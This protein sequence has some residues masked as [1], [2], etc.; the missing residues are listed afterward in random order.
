MTFLG[1]VRPARW[2]YVVVDVKAHV[3]GV[4]FTTMHLAQGCVL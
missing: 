2:A 1:S 4:A 3:H